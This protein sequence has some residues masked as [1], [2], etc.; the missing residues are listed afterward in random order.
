MFNKTL[1]AQKTKNTGYFNNTDISWIKG[2]G[3][4]KRYTIFVTNDES[5]W[6]IVT[7]NGIKHKSS[8]FGIGAGYEQWANSYT[9]PA[10]LRYQLFIKDIKPSIFE[11]IDAG[12]AF[13][14]AKKDPEEKGRFIFSIGLGTNIKID[15]GTHISLAFFYKLQHL[16]VESYNGDYTTNYNF[17]G[18]KVGVAFY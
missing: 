17:I 3:S 11:Y 10:F 14:S 15:K 2:V 12:Y 5:N 18:L 1:P 16:L 9:I 6:A 4:V 8:V 7:V 13:G